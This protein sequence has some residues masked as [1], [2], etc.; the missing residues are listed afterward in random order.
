[1]PRDQILAWDD[2][3]LDGTPIFIFSESVSA[4]RFVPRR[5]PD[6]GQ[7]LLSRCGP[8]T[9]KPAIRLLRPAT[10]RDEAVGLSALEPAGV[11]D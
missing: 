3:L 11:S 2:D 8:L 5:A 10:A 4:H 9:R 7:R 6:K 1:M